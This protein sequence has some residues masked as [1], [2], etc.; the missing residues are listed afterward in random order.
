MKIVAIILT[1]TL[2]GVMAWLVYDSHS[3]ADGMRNELE[4]LRRQMGGG[5]A[6][7]AAPNPGNA[8]TPVQTIPGVSESDVRA[9]QELKRQMAGSSQPGVPPISPPPGVLPSAPGAP[10]PPPPSGFAGGTP[11]GSIPGAMTTPTLDPATVAPPPVS[12]RQR[13]IASLPRIAQVTDYNREAGFLVI[14]AG[15][16]RKLEK[17]M[18]LAIRRG[19]SLI[20]RI[21]VTE[22][23]PEGAVADVP[24]NSIYPGATI[25]VGD[26]V[27]QDVPPDA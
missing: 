25:E 27:I 2:L 24:S 10:V 20:A 1:S 26:D 16:A 9:G 4:L 19:G 7:A 22:V 12:Q 15:A 14:N 11:A 21:Q 6:E 8:P 18:K 23:S 17:D 13:M 3:Q 5:Q